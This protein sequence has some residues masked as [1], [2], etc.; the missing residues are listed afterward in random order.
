MIAILSMW[1]ND[2]ERR[3]LDRVTHLNSKTCDTHPLRHLWIV[4][5]GDD[6]SDGTDNLLAHYAN[7]LD[8][9]VTMVVE[10]TTVTGDSVESIRRRASRSATRLFE[11]VL[12]SDDYVLLHESD[13]TS[14]DNVIDLLLPTVESTGGPVAGWPTLTRNGETIFYDIWAYRDIDGDRFTHGVKLDAVTQVTSFGSVWLAEAGLVRGRE[15]TDE[16]IVEL[17]GEWMVEGVGM[18]VDPSIP[19]VQPVDLWN[20]GGKC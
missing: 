17:C 15:I 11:E 8:M 1:R 14:P 13:L 4:S 18:F 19:V 9:D 12:P 2:S 16:G 7:E 20:G 10:S 3:L 5:V 6:C